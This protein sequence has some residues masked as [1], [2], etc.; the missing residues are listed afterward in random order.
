MECAPAKAV[1]RSGGAPPCA[2]PSRSLPECRPPAPADPAPRR[3]PT[4]ARRLRARRQ[5]L[6]PPGYACPPETAPAASRSAGRRGGSHRREGSAP[7]PSRKNTACAPESVAHAPC[8]RR[9][10]PARTRR[11]R[12]NGRSARSEGFHWRGRGGCARRIRPTWCRAPIP[13]RKSG[14][15]RQRHTRSAARRTEGATLAW[16]KNGK[17]DV[18]ETDAVDSRR[19][20]PRRQAPRIRRRGI[21]VAV[22]MAKGRLVGSRPCRRSSMSIAARTPA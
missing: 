2:R 6:R 3:R 19:R 16:L 9:P 11:R 13:G 5:S 10:P 20:P 18:R 15:R 4:S 22:C 21:C 7:R 17:T 12:R 14:I 1:R 8:S